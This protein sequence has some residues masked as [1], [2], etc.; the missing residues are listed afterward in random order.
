[1]EYA[2]GGNLSD[3]IISAKL[4]KMW[5]DTS[6]I[7]DWISQV[8]LGVQLMHSK[9]IL[10]RDLKSQN[11]F[12]TKDGV[13]KIG[14]FGIA[15]ELETIKKLTETNVGTPYFMSPEVVRGE[16][17]GEKADVW[18]IGVILYEMTFL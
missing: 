1:M 14:D 3:K 18:A 15:K 10:H 9:R 17:Y 13:L 4:K 12:L 7:L 6:S 8:I 2:E 16:P 11:L 5:F